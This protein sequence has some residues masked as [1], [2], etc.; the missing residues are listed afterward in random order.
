MKPHEFLAA[1]IAKCGKNG[2]WLQREHH[3][4]G[5][6]QIRILTGNASRVLLDEWFVTG[7]S[8]KQA[9]AITDTTNDYID[10]RGNK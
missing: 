10:S 4:G 5:K 3:G 6:T 2:L 9:Q 7:D 1:S 8:A